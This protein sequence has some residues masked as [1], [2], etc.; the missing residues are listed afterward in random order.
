M[1]V[2]TDARTAV[3]LLTRLP[4]LPRSGGESG[5]GLAGAVGYF[6]LVGLLIAAAGVGTWAILEP[7]LGP[8]VAALAS[9]LATVVV[10]GAMHEDGL[11]DVADGF[12]GGSTP[13]RRLEIMRDSRVG[14]F[15]VLAVTGD[16]LLRAALLA[17]LDLANVVRVLVAGHVIGRAAPLVLVAWLPPAR[18]NGLGA[19]MAKPRRSGVVLATVTVVTA[20]V[21]VAGGWG[22]VP[23]VAAGAAVAAVGWIA[24]RR[25]G[26]YTG[27]VLGA[28]VLMVNLAVAAAVA[29]L[30]RAGWV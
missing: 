18:A 14:T 5:G 24:H 23:I 8:L 10:T 12:W 25:I 2:L 19:R 15:G 30:A 16:V 29:A 4:V 7:V 13:Q 11:A 21:A 3:G 6:P 27:D 9:V 26:G 28:G 1:S 22:A 20:A 17:S